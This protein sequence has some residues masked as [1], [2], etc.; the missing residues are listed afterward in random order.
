MTY[1]SPAKINLFLHVTSK[2]SDGYHNLQT[3]FQLVDYCDEININYRSDEIIRRISGNENIP[4]DQDLTIRSATLLKKI[5]GS[6]GGA[7]ISI[8]KKIPIGSGLG[9]GSSNAA[10][11]LI[12]LNELWNLNLSKE[13]LVDIGQHIGADV[14]VFIIGRSSWGEGIGEILT[15]ISLPKYFYLI[16]SIGKHISTKEIFTHK[17]LTMSPVQRKM[18]DFSLVSNPHNDC[19]EAAIDIE[20]EIEDALIH[21]NSTEKHIDKA[22]M[23]GSGSC[24]Y[25][26]FEREEDAII[27]KKELPIKWLGFIAK[28]IN[29]SPLCNWDVAKW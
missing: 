11:V 26:A 6:K 17:A 4:Q 20:G 12:A 18:S 16:V 15:P 10:T 24:V 1:L 23:S 13:E 7:D 25:V 29:K 28:A 9:G 14:P 8:V 22:R 5:T 3:I 19:L 27:A 21:L 2:R